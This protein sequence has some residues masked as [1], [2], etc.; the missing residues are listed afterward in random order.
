MI[1]LLTLH[2]PLLKI[3]QTANKQIRNASVAFLTR[4]ARHKSTQPVLHA[5]M[6]PDSAYPRKKGHT[7]QYVPFL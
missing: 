1:E 5:S 4:V 2:I 3:Y 6:Q 7:L